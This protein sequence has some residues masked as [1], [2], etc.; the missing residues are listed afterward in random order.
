MTAPSANWD[1]HEFDPAGALTLPERIVH[2]VQA[3]IEG[4]ARD[5]Y[6]SPLGD[7]VDGYSVDFARVGG[8][9]L[10]DVL[11]EDLKW[12]APCA[13][14]S[15]CVNCAKVHGQIGHLRVLAQAVRDVP[16][17]KAV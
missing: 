10:V 6:P 13:P 11:A 1:G 5:I 9:A 15:G 4:A 14:D 3:A 17:L 8:A 16:A 2:A 12:Q 7:R